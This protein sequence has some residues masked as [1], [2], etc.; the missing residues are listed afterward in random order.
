VNVGNGT[1]LRDHSITVSS[2]LRPKVIRL[3]SA[4]VKAQHT[5]QLNT[6]TKSPQAGPTSCARAGTDESPINGRTSATWLNPLRHPGTTWV[7]HC[8]GLRWHGIYAAL[9]CRLLLSPSTTLLLYCTFTLRFRDMSSIHDET[10]TVSETVHKEPLGEPASQGTS[11]GEKVR[12]G[13]AYVIHASVFTPHMLT[14]YLQRRDER[15][16][17]YLSPICNLFSLT[18]DALVRNWR[19]NSRGHNRHCRFRQW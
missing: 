19:D 14:W 18:I 8:V 2:S 15:R 10:S 13:L 7:I 9:K 4:S 12:H 11:L 6:K 5:V 3:L 17:W 16:S 1:S